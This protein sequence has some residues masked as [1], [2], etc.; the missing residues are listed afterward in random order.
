MCIRDSASTDRTVSSFTSNRLYALT[1]LSQSSE[2]APEQQAPRGSDRVSEPVQ[3]I[4][5]AVRIALGRANPNISL[6]DVKLKDKAPLNAVKGLE[7]RLI[8]SKGNLLRKLVVPVDEGT[9]RIRIDIDLPKG[10]FDAQVLTLSNA[11]QSEAVNSIPGVVERSFFDRIPS[12]KAP[13]LKGTSIVAPRILFDPNS[14]RLSKDTKEALRAIA[15]RLSASGKRVALTGFAAQGIVSEN[16]A[17]ALSA[18]R[19][20]RVARF[21]RSQ[22]MTEWI[23]FSG[24]GSIP[25]Q[26]RVELS[27][28]VEIRILD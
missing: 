9:D 5:S 10:T 16:Q 24:F 21:L 3:Q 15:K 1:R 14:A 4:V 6:L 28:K 2:P 11:G 25:T 22:G 23:F 27:R 7:V 20:A 17:Q 18:K 26:G 19:A 8:D 13:R 12:A